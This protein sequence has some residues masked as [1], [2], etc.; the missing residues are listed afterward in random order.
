MTEKQIKKTGEIVLGIGSIVGLILMLTQVDVSGYYGSHKEFSPINISL[1][2]ALII[3]SFLI[4][5]SC[6]WMSQMLENS[7]VQNSLLKVIIEQINETE[8]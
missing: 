8:N 5:V 2:L 4:Y 6:S 7:K 3:F 1:G